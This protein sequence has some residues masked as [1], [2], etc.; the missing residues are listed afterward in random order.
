M[1]PSSLLELLG[2]RG[3]FAPQAPGLPWR[4]LGLWIVSGGA[5]YGLVMGA[6]GGRIL[7][8][9]YSASKVPVLV[10]GATALCLPSFFVVNAVLGLRADFRAALR[11]I[12]AAQGTVAV[13]LG[14][15]A[16]VLLLFYVSRVSYPVALLLNG[17][18]FAVA[19]FAGQCTLRRHY[20]VLIERNG[21]HR[22]ALTAW[23]ALYVFVSI[24]LGWMLRPFIGD[25]SLPL[26]YLRAE[27]WM[28]N[29]YANLFWTAAALAWRI[30]GLD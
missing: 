7:G 11:G 16:P 3:V 20:A 28:E 12:L 27:Q 19:S 24:K 6:L 30:L 14:G 22:I 5:L 25:P 15:L 9:V 29:P 8:G 23:F 18:L 2:A 13:C 1:A 17:G 4:L 10:L 26:E 21:R